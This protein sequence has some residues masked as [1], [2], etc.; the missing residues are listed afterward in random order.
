MRNKIILAVFLCLFAVLS[1]LY[2]SWYAP[3]WEED[4][5]AQALIDS[6]VPADVP[7][8]ILNPFAADF[9]SVSRATEY[10]TLPD[11]PFIKIGK[12]G[13]V[14]FR[15]FTGK[16]TLVNL[17]ATWCAPCVVELPSLQKLEKHYKDHMN[18]IAVSVQDVKTPPEIAQF[19][20]KRQIGDF[21]AYAD[22]D[23][24]IVK[25]LGI[26]GIPISFLIGSEGQILYRF[27]GDADWT[28]ERSRAFFDH[29]LFQKK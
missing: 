25:N 10:Q 15:D 8:N 14:Y 19:L 17:W 12:E 2:Y 4:A 9:N 29:F 6:F 5:R 26:R 13:E 18:V 11:S 16:P 3:E 21:A 27:E 24:L 22:P 1:W 20:E 7:E 28:S 23:G